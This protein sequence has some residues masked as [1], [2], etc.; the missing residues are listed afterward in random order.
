VERVGIGCAKLL[1]FGEHSALYGYPSVGLGLPESTEIRVSEDSSRRWRFPDL[2]ANEAER[3]D[4]L[5]E[6]AA[7]ALPGL[8]GGGGDIRITSTIA[9]ALGFGSSAAL[10][11]AL[12]RAFAPAGTGARELWSIAHRA[13]GFFHGRPSGIDTGLSL[14]GGLISFAP[15]RP[16]PRHRPLRGPRACLVVGALPRRES[17][18]ALVGGLAARMASGDGGARA[19]IEELGSIA[20]R[21]IALIDRGGSDRPVSLSRLGE[22][23]GAAHRALGGLGL[24]DRGVDRLISFGLDHGAYGGKQSGAG[25]GGA[26]FL[27]YPTEAAAMASLSSISALAQAEGLAFASPLRIVNLH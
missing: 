13:E 4:G 14:H 17:T 2:A 26:F 1:L 6:R 23:L 9:P 16:L 24:G 19:L 18:A 5:L 10:C 12:A 20:E 15:S 8:R 25:S 21:A 11:V 3:L 7:G 27:L 22:L